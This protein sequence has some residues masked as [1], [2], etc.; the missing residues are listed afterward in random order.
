MYT[1]FMRIIL[2]VSVYCQNIVYM[3]SK[4]QA[5]HQNNRK[6]VVQ[7]LLVGIKFNVENSTAYTHVLLIFKST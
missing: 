4:M 2:C 5:I 3:L 6:F 7:L 1:W